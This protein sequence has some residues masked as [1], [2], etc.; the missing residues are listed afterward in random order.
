MRKVHHFCDLCKSEV[1]EERSLETVTVHSGRRSLNGISFEVCRTC[2]KE[3]ESGVKDIYAAY[4]GYHDFYKS[5]LEKLKEVGR[6]A[7]RTLTR[8]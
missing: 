7:I 2:I 6:S 8:K 4:F 1:E 5:F 3:I